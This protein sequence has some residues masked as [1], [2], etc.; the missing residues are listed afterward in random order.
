M[1]KNGKTYF[2]LNYVGPTGKHL[3]H[4]TYFTQ[5]G[6]PA[7]EDTQESIHPRVRFGR[8]LFPKVNTAKEK[9]A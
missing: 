6:E 8:T 7:K 4:R 2:E 9:R 3:S 1:K 5:T